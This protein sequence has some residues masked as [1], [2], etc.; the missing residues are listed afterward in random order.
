[1]KAVM[2]LCDG[3]KTR[4]RV[5]TEL[6]EEFYVEVGIHQ[7]SVLSPLFA[8]VVDEIT[9]YDSK[10]AIKGRSDLHLHLV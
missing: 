4:I 5:G 10:H 1:M 6:S 3:A 2:S 8:I 9:A 7:E